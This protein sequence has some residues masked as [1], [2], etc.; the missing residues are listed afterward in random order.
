MSEFPKTDRGYFHLTE[1]GWMRQDLPPF[2]ANRAETWRYEMERP[3]EDAK[4]RGLPD[5][6]LEPPGHQR[7]KPRSAAEPL[8]RAACA[9]TGTQH[10]PGMQCV[11]AC[12]PDL[13][14]C[15]VVRPPPPWTF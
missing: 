6:N 11:T 4:E 8:W 13:R 7:G 9:H 10:H 14:C 5:K 2:P 12:R 1:H 3:A 15:S